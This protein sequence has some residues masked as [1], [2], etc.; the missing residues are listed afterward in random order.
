MT[1]AGMCHSDVLTGKNDW[2]LP[3]DG[4]YPLVPGHEIVGVV[5]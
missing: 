3:L 5:E 2:C 4:L 1:Y